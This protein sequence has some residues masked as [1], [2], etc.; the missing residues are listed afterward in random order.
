MWLNVIAQNSGTEIPPDPW[1][2]MQTLAVVLNHLGG[3][4]PQALGDTI[5]QRPNGCR[6]RAD[7]F[8]AA[9]RSVEIVQHKFV[10]LV[11]RQQFAIASKD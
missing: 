5:T 7:G 11:S 2:E 3:G 10:S 1:Q 8:Q 6:L 4:Q 9:A